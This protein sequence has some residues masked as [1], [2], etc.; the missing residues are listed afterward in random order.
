MN[1]DNDYLVDATSPEQ[2]VSQS[3]EVQLRERLSTVLGAPRKSTTYYT[4]PNGCVT[5]TWEE[6]FFHV[7]KLVARVEALEQNSTQNIYEDKDD[8]V[9]QINKTILGN[10]PNVS[11]S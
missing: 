1:N 10:L 2:F 4:A 3:T 7:G 8:M 11:N 6:I 9:R 5:Y